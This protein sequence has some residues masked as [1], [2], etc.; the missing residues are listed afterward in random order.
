MSSTQRQYL[1]SISAMRCFEAASRHQSFTQAAEELYLTQSAVSR[2][3]KELE[4]L[5]GAQLFR[6]TGREVVLTRAGQQLAADIRPE[7]DNI[8]RIVMKA[9]SAGNLNSTLRIATLPTFASLWLIPRLE[10]FL[11]RHQDIEISLSTR[12]KPFDL[13]EEHFDAAIHFG[14][15]NWPNT[16]MRLFFTE[17]MLPVA[18]PKLVRRYQLTSLRSLN[19]VPLLHTSTRP[20]AWEDFFLNLGLEEYSTLK[21][22]QFDQFSMVI[23][24]AH[25]S[26]G[27]A[28][29]PKYLI[30]KDLDDGSLVAI[31]SAEIATQNSYYFVTPSDQDNDNVEK[32]RTWMFEQANHSPRV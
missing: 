13:V 9:V 24:A 2:Q 5:I 27:V 11:Q 15:E 8:R 12:L 32:F 28:L 30:K 22:R 10:N 16:D 6:R 7:L 4:Q 21:G 23:A 18:S 19:G 31:S 3:V 26:L 17:R 25:A 29:L 20:T 1:P 14:Q